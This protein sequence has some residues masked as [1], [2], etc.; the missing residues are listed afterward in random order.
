MIGFNLWS[1]GIYHPAE[2]V[3][4]TV[5]QVVSIATSSG[6]TTTTYG[7]WPVFSLGILLFLMFV[8]G[9]AGSTAGGFKAIRLIVLL[10]SAK[11]A[12]TKNIY[13]KSVTAVK[14]GKQAVSEDI[15]DGMRNL[16]MAYMTVFSIT[17]LFLLA[18][19]IDLVTSISASIACLSNIG[20]GLG[21]IRGSSNY[22]WMPDAVKLYLSTAMIVGRLEFFTVLVLFLP[23]AWKR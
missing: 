5:F 15:L 11:Q 8:G 20:P 1:A 7:S 9:C 22:A 17:T 13:S 21:E 2:L 18:F 3:R 19:D 10:K 23:A 12:L 6:F 16:F 14:I 4:H